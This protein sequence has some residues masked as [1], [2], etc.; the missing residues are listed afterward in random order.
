M[1]GRI[2][3][4]KAEHSG[5][6]GWVRV[7]GVSDNGAYLRFPTVRGEMVAFVAEDDVW[8]A[9]RSGGRGG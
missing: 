8:L 9:T 7:A 3:A 5:C 6:S 1:P 2:R 4:E